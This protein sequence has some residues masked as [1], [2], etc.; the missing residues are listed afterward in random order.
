MSYCS[1]SSQER[2]IEAKPCNVGENRSPFRRVKEQGNQSPVLTKYLIQGRCTGEL[3]TFTILNS[4]HFLL[5]LPMAFILPGTGII[6]LATENT[7]ILGVLP[8]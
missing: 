8:Y 3:E 5:N 1:N 7:I 4:G 2:A 6:S